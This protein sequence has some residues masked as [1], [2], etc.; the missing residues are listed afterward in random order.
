[1]TRLAK[2]EIF[3]GKQ[4]TIEEV[5]TRYDAVSGQDLQRLSQELFRSD[6]LHME[7]MGRVA[8]LGLSEAMLAV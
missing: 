2:N 1:M 3:L 5:L 7:V 4:Q 6:S 8:D